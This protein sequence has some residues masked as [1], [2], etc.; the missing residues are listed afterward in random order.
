[1]P[2]Q[3][4]PDAEGEREAKRG[5]STR[6]KKEAEVD[7]LLTTL[8]DGPGPVPFADLLEPEGVKSLSAFAGIDVKCGELRGLHDKNA[9]VFLVHVYDM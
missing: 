3:T 4:T 5:R 9:R 1:M 7:I 8:S 6:T 2:S